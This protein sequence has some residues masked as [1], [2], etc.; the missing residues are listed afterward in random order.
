MD[1]QAGKSYKDDALGDA[2]ERVTG[3]NTIEAK[4]YF[5]H[6]ILHPDVIVVDHPR[7]G[8][9]EAGFFTMLKNAAWPNSIYKLW[10]RHARTRS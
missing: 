1:N 6:D 7:K 8:C 3:N 4:E 5:K 2:A 9:D 10:Q